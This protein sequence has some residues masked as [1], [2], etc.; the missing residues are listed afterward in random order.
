VLPSGAWFREGKEG[1][2]GKPVAITRSIVFS[3]LPI[4]FDRNFG[5]YCCSALLTTE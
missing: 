2:E 1:S 3:A 5:V 4:S